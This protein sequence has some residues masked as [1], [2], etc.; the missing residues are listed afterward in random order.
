MSG[1]SLLNP[2]GLLLAA[3]VIPL[4]LLYILK[5]RRRHQPVSSTWLWAAAQR[6]LVAKHPFRKLVPEVPLLLE[7][8]ALAAL[9]IA[10]ARPSSLGGGMDGDHVVIVVDTS[11]SM[12]T[13]V[14]DP[15]GTTTRMDEAKR[16]ARELVLR[17]GPGS[18]AMIVEAGRDARI[19][20][21][22]ERDPRRLE[23]ALATLDAREVEGDLTSA[24]ALAAERLRSL[25]GHTCLVVVT[26]GAL[27]H[28]EP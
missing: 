12:A 24:A 11:A 7:L 19:V 2:R 13:R 1:L 15:A 6:D 4:V 25:G 26:D 18:D 27:A 17:L 8:L 20:S 22:F 21:P 16:A 28:D 9:A 5:I 3:G 10:L 23:A 14:G